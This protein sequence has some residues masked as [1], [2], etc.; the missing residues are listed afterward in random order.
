MDV[1]LVILTIILAVVLLGVNFYFLIYY[2]DASEKGFSDSWFLKILVLIG[3]MLAWAQVLTLPLDVSNTK[4][5]GGGLRIDIMWQIIFMSVFIYVVVLIPTA[6]F[7]YE[8]DEEETVASRLCYT[9]K[10]LAF[11][12]VI[13]GLI[14][15]IMYLLLATTHIPVETYTCAYSSSSDSF[16]ECD[17]GETTLKIPVTFPVYVM[18]LLS[19]VGWFLLVMFGGIGLSAIPLDFINMYRFRPQKLSPQE[20]SAKERSLRNNAAQLRERISSLKLKKAE[21]DIETSWFKKRSIKNSIRTETNRIQAETLILEQQYDSY[22]LEKGVSK[23]S[24]LWYPVYLILGIV[25]L[26]VS[27]LLLLHTLLYVAIRSDGIP[28]HPF[29]NEMLIGL[30]HPSV[31]FLSTIVYAIFAIYLLLAVIKGN[32]KFGLRFFFCFQAHPIKKD[33]TPMNSVLFNLNL[34]LMASVAVTLYSA[35]AFSMF[36]RL[37]DIN[38][39]FGIQVR[40]LEFFSYFYANNVF[41]IMLLCWAFLTGIYL[42]FKSRDTAPQSN[43]DIEYEK[44]KLNFAKDQK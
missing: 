33:A 42:S 3:L 32:I 36:T 2:L 27:L 25:T 6:S 37:T 26:I 35:N 29:L 39:M 11:V 8:S 44:Q 1:F 10:H 17:E 40:Y 31:S 28:A 20:L 22:M 19:F 13:V 41:E 43:Y 30:E 12:V 23:K 16:A 18:G 4:G 9:F 15:T 34:I 14:L 7:Y 21:L 24:D 38:N 5:E